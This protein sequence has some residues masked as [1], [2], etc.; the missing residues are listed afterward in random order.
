MKKSELLPKQEISKGSVSSDGTP[1]GLY[2][3]VP[4]GQ[5][6]GDACE[7]ALEKL[8][9]QPSGEEGNH[10]ENDFLEITHEEIQ[11]TKIG[12]IRS[13]KEIKRPKRK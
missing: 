2:G 8:E 9:V 6:A 7:V 1:G 5:E 10:L 3:V 4:G 12:N 13:Y 11:R